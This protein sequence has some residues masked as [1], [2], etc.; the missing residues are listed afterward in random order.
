MWL[1]IV[2]D[3]TKFLATEARE[4]YARYPWKGGDGEKENH[5]PNAFEK[6]FES[7]LDA[8][9]SVFTSH[10][11]H[12]HL[13]QCRL[14]A[15]CKFLSLDIL[16]SKKEDEKNWVKLKWIEK[17]ISDVCRCRMIQKSQLPA[18]IYTELT[19][20]SFH[21]PQNFLHITQFSWKLRC[22]STNAVRKKIH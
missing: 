2:K 21:F 4:I 11:A 7:F 5:A 9:K 22:E 8:S 18:T 13:C 14:D 19:S 3:E 6:V 16:F 15:R 17:L 12:E 1:K 20:E 10:L